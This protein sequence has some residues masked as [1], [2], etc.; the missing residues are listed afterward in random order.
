[1]SLITPQKGDHIFISDVH[2]GGFDEETNREVEER[3]LEFLDFVHEQ[4][5]RL[6]VLGDLF[7][8]WMEYRGE[9][10]QYGEQVLKAFEKINEQWPVLYITGNHD[11][12]VGPRIAG[13]G[14]DLEHEFRKLRIGEKNV[15]MLHGDGL[16][17]P[18]MHMPRARFHRLLRNPYFVSMYQRIF[19]PKMGIRIMRQ[20]SHKS[21][22]RDSVSSQGKNQS[23]IDAWAED[24]L[25]RGLADV[26]ICGHHHHPVYK[27]TDDGLYINLGNFCRD[28]TMALHT[29]SGFS[30]VRWQAETKQFQLLTP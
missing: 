5:F 16:K 8:Y 2:L 14:F 21:K 27:K 6:S 20:F 30:L 10:P 28:S 9:W 7:D 24:S 17:D 4:G 22:L 15:L 29:R 1:M 23:R 12:W 11:N 18:Q 19:P 3:L 26:V 13:A 25:K